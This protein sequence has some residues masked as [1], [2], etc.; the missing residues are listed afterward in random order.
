MGISQHILQG[1]D[2]LD[3]D[4]KKEGKKNT[5]HEKKTTNCIA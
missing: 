2:Y 5:S 4:K 1:Q 3:F